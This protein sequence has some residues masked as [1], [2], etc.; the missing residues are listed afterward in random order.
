MADRTRFKEKFA[1]SQLGVVFAAFFLILQI[2]LNRSDEF[3]LFIALGILIIT[4]FFYRIL[5]PVNKLWMG[6]G[7]LMGK[8]VGT[9]LLAIIFFL[10]L[11]PLSMLRKLA[12]GK[13]MPISFSENTQSFW[14]KR[15]AKKVECIDFERQF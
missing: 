10:F 5:S 3:F 14:V 6:F 8:I 11:T 9:I 1:L 2:S 4:I 7:H 15:D 13:G 12:G